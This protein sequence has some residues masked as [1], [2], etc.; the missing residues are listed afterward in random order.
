MTY[1]VSLAL[2]IV[3]V[4]EKE[5]LVYCKQLIIKNI[6]ILW[7]LNLTLESFRNFQNLSYG[8]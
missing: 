4:T 7:P 3:G 2:A 8:K 6:F 5:G 1:E